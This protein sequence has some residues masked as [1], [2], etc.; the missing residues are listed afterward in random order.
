MDLSRCSG[1]EIEPHV[2]FPVVLGVTDHAR[3]GIVRHH[4]ALANG[5]ATTVEH[6]RIQNRHSVL[7]IRIVEDELRP[8][9]PLL[10]T[11]VLRSELIDF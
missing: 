4:E 10:L 7:K 9:R 3:A 8:P 5:F 2:V 11:S 6:T 1:S